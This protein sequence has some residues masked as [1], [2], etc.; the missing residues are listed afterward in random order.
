MRAT[1]PKRSLDQRVQAPPNSAKRCGR[2]MQSAAR[3]SKAREASRSAA[4]SP[5]TVLLSPLLCTIQARQRL[6]ISLSRAASSFAILDGRSPPLPNPLRS[7]PKP[8]VVQLRQARG[9]GLAIRT[10]EQCD[11]VNA[12]MLHALEYIYQPPE[13]RVLQRLYRPAAVEITE[14]ARDLC[15]LF[16]QQSFHA[17]AHL[18]NLIHSPTIHL[19]ERKVSHETVKG[20]GEAQL[21]CANCSRKN[22]FTYPAHS[23]AP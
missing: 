8:H 3:R 13:L 14:G 7:R 2:A 15:T 5:S 11:L 10:Q 9:Y 22:H 20:I 6:V 17:L 18:R 16:A 12:N 19:V 21:P 4:L 1:D 23:H